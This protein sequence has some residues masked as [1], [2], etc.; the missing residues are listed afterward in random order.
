[1]I[2]EGSRVSYIGEPILGVVVGDNG[3]VVDSLPTHSHVLW[4]CGE[5]KG[6]IDLVSNEALVVS[7][8]RA[9]HNT[10]AAEMADSLAFGTMAVEGVRA[11]YD[12]HGVT[13][14]VGALAESGHMT[15]LTELA[16]EA[17]LGMVTAIRSNPQVVE[18]LATL[19]PEDQD[20][21][22][23][24]MAATLLADSAKGVD[25]DE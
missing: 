9:T 23:E 2:V 25:D 22:I 11:V 3:K 16:D 20:L 12:E 5:R 1:M 14:V 13:G 15:M 24:R 19:E 6:M 21:V 18:V 4:A 8:S 10:V 7:S 17:V